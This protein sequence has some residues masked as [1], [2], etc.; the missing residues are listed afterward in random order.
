MLPRRVVAAAHRPCIGRSQLLK[1]RQFSI[2][3]V[4]KGEIEIT[5]D[6]KKVKVEQGAALIQACEKAGV[7]I[8]RSISVPIF[9]ANSVDTVIMIN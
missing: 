2:S 6:G 7:Q 9:T 3:S 8:P 4:R 5:V 1:C